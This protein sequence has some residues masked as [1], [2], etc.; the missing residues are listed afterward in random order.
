MMKS[1]DWNSGATILRRMFARISC[2][3]VACLWIALNVHAQ[4][5]ARHVRRVSSD[6]TELPAWL[7]VTPTK[8]HRPQSA[9]RYLPP[10]ERRHMR[11]LVDE[12]TASQLEGDEDT[13]NPHDTTRKLQADASKYVVPVYFHVIHYDSETGTVSDDAIASWMQDLNRNFA[14]SLL[15]FATK[16]RTNVTKPAWFL[17]SPTNENRM[18]RTLRVGGKGTLNVFLC[19]P[20]SGVF[21]WATPPSLSDRD[22]DLDGVVLFSSPVPETALHYFNQSDTLTQLTAEWLGLVP[23]YTVGSPLDIVLFARSD[24]VCHLSHS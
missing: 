7:S 13:S 23:T 4:Q 15:T 1:S 20:N 17:C 14:G 21:G 24:S 3:T 11:A 9:T 22:T 6:D 10:E 18:K 19:Q 5:S 16:G 2:F 12:Y 8:D